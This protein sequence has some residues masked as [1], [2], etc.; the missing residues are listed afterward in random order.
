MELIEIRSQHDM[1]AHVPETRR[2]VAHSYLVSCRQFLYVLAKGRKPNATQGPTAKPGTTL[3]FMTLAAEQI[4]IT[5]E[6]ITSIVAA[7]QSA[8]SPVS[9]A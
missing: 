1:T 2:A 7:I 9:L 6:E 8:H 5:E 4:W 3:G